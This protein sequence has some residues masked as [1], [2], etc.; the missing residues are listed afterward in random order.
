MNVQPGDMARIVAP[1]A[2]PGVGA[3]VSVVS[4]MTRE[5]RCGVN[6]YFHTPNTWI[7]HGWVL[8]EQRRMQGPLLAVGDEFLRRI[9]PFT[10]EL[11]AEGVR[12]VVV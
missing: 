5:L 6:W 8:D 1:Y 7:V 10:G 2:A 4:P 11:V 3:V 9:D 12:E